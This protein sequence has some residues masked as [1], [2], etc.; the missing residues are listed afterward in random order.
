M[1][2]QESDCLFQLRDPIF[3]TFKFAHIYMVVILAGSIDS[4]RTVK[5]VSYMKSRPWLIRSA[6][7]CYCNQLL[8]DGLGEKITLP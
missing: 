2:N 3:S 5:A 7:P 8:A 4:P 6:P 1:L